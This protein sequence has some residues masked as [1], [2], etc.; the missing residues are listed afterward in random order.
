MNIYER[1]FRWKVL[2]LILALA[3][4][5]VTLWYTNSL[6]TKITAEENKKVQQWATASY[7]L[8][9][10]NENSDEFRFLEDIVTSNSTIPVIL[11]DDKDQIASW[12]FLDSVKVARD[13]SYLNKQ[14]EIMRN[15]N[16]PIELSYSIE[17]N[18]STTWDLNH[19]IYYKDSTLLTQLKFYPFVQL[20]TI[21][22]FLL[23]SYLAFS[24]ARKAEQNQVWVG[25]AKETAHQL[26]TPLS[27]M[28]GWV[29]YLRSK[30]KE[31][32]KN[33]VSEELQKDVD[34]L[35]LITERFS[36]IGSQPKM[37][38]VD[39]ESELLKTMN[40]VKRR[41]SQRIEFSFENTASEKIAQFSPPLFDWVV[42]NILKNALDAM[43]GT[44]NVRLE[45]SDNEKEHI[46]DIYNSGKA[47]PKNKWKTVFEPGYSTKKRG[48]GLGLSLS[49]RI[50]EQYHRGRVF[51]KQSKG[52]IGT[53]FRIL[54]PK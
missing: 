4:A 8:P 35:H 17:L 19:R 31:S 34:R 39:I 45:V 5:A 29:E 40:Y 27:S 25:M 21:G 33:K 28:L 23:L 47:L 54:L 30:E 44:G 42:E 26:G 48:W 49:K 3:I 37:E 24:S 18:D 20:A 13:T 15:Q 14:M 10:S 22:L 12:R 2:L 46:I 32:D 52:N 11:T 51:V 1:K 41:A 6:A 43:D 7:L 50:I 16:K 36:K 38:A 9:K 53:T